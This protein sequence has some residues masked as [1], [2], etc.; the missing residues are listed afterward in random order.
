MATSWPA[1]N[2]IKAVEL[3]ARIRDVRD[4]CVGGVFIYCEV[5]EVCIE[6]EQVVERKCRL[7]PLTALSAVPN[8]HD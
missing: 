1:I 5:V 6:Q 8:L 3:K 7:R 4:V 2:V